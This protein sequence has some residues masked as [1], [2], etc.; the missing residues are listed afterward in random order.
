M[1]ER[2]E[3]ILIK[4]HKKSVSEKIDA[5]KHRLIMKRE[6]KNIIIKNHRKSASEK[7]N[8]TRSASKNRTL[9]D[10]R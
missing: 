9:K 8:H 5:E 3:I 6:I 1:K 7:M 10:T 2:T 4:N